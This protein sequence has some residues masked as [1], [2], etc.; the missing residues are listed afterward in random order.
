MSEELKKIIL[1]K[2]KILKEI[3]Y[4]FGILERT[5]DNEEKKMIS[6]QINLLEDSLKKRNNKIPF[7]L[8]VMSS[9]KPLTTQKE[10][11]NIESDIKEIASL[12][13]L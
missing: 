8:K 2:K 11:K 9:V 6:S 7:I 3:S 13:T 10:T 4:L 5:K 1:E 12:L